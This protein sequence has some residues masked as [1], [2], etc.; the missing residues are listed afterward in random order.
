MR[1]VINT[2]LSA[3][4][5]D[6]LRSA[7]SAKTEV[8]LHYSQTKKG[9]LK[10]PLLEKARVNSIEGNLRDYKYLIFLAHSLDSEYV[11]FHPEKNELGKLNEIIKEGMD[12]GIHVAVENKETIG[13]SPTDIYNLIKEFPGLKFVFNPSTAKAC[14][15]QPLSFIKMLKEHIIGINVSDYYKGISNIPYSLGET[16][17]LDP[18][19]DKYRD[20]KIPF[21]IKLDSR[22]D[23]NDALISIDKIKERSKGLKRN[24]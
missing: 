17:F 12:K 3:N 18:V 20:E 16:D 11:L 24:I 1:F 23:M 7:V 10:E 2:F 9:F 14:S 15:L 6:I 21:V 5:Q 4:F 13:R 22:Y 8:E 19:I